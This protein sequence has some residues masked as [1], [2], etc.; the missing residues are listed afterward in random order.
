VPLRSP[1]APPRLSVLDQSSNVA[2]PA[3]YVAVAVAGRS[4][5]MGGS[6]AFFNGDLVTDTVSRGVGVDLV[7]C[8]PSLS[9]RLSDAVSLTRC[10][11]LFGPR[12]I[13]V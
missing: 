2:N 13:C 7:L 12:D 1:E 4:R 10:L 9:E 3:T 8:T 6:M 11:V 5:G